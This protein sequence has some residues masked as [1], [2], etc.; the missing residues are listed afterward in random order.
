MTN[1]FQ[2]L[3]IPKELRDT[4]NVEV[5]TGITSQEITTAGAGTW[6]KPANVKMIFVQIIGAG[7]G[8]GG[9]ACRTDTTARGGGTGG[10]GGAYVDM[11]IPGD[12]M[13]SAVDYY[14]SAG[15]I[16]GNGGA[17]SGNNVGFAASANSATGIFYR[18]SLPIWGL[19]APSG[20]RGAGGAIT[21]VDVYG[22]GGAGTGVQADPVTSTPPGTGVAGGTGASAGSGGIPAQ[23]G[24]RW[25]G[26]GGAGG[27]SSITHS[28]GY[29]AAYSSENGGGGGGGSPGTT[30]S[31]RIF[32]PIS[33][34]NSTRGGGGGGAGF[35]YGT[36]VMA[37][38][39]GL[40]YGG[41]GGGVGTLAGTVASPNGFNGTGPFMVNEGIYSV[42]RNLLGGSGGGGGCMNTGVTLAGNGGNGG[43]WGGGG[44]GGA[45]GNGAVPGGNGG[46]GGNGGIRFTL[47]F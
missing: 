22:G 21:L 36:G 23:S 46:N 26:V 30:L 13:P 2:G 29:G 19:L 44:G 16:G 43:P 24:I 4:L 33:G 15:G 47:F 20:G 10:G 14:V 6:Y 28:S 11:W 41:G 39:L 9:G 37:V 7:G 17:A 40:G 1:Y 5:S 34:G 27:A 18:S 8:G 38:S 32:T 25:H 42:F 35:G 45:A 31:P 3:P 12:L